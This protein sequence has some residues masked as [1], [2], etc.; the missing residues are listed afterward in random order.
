MRK[1]LLTI[2]LVAGL[3]MGQAQDLT[4]ATFNC[5]WLV[6]S[7]VHVKFGLPYNLSTGLSRGQITQ[8][9]FDQWQNPTFRRT[10]LREASRAVAQHILSLNADFV[11]LTEVGRE[12]AVEVL[13]QELDSLGSPFRFHALGDSKDP[14]GQHVLM[15]SVHRLKAVE[16]SFPNRGLYYLEEDKDDV[17][18]TGLSK[19]MKA[20][21]TVDGVDMNI[22]LVHF[23]S[24]RGGQESDNQ[25]IKQ[26]ELVREINLKYLRDDEHVIVMGDINSERNHEA[27][28][29]L[30]GFNDVY[31]EL[32]QTGDYKYMSEGSIRW[33][34]T[35]QGLQDQ[36]DH[37][38]MSL[39]L[40][41]E[42][43][44]TKGIVTTIIPT[45]NEL[46]SD[47][48]AVVVKLTFR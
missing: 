5:E 40:T 27:L 9:E 30:R 7:R 47:H 1:L 24:E 41:K 21:I 4:I 20:K 3:A 34:Y 14:T 26:A 29:M 32:V 16:D 23:K 25:R 22:F 15:L 6:E 42:F 19:G 11:G 45:E 35:F 10:K 44:A 18:E 46:V 36:L 17:K 12:P 2:C 28:S 43:K 13:L 33:T 8:A 39:P 38:L 31:Q 37:I 48:N